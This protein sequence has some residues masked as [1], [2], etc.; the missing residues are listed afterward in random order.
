MMLDFLAV[1]SE[2]RVASLANMSV[3]FALTWRALALVILGISVLRAH[4]VMVTV[5]YR[6][7]RVPVALIVIVV[8]AVSLEVGSS[9]A[10][11][12]VGRVMRHGGGR[13]CGAGRARVH[14]LALV[15][16]AVAHSL[17]A[18]TVA[19]AVAVVAY[20]AVVGAS[21]TVVAASVPLLKTARLALDTST[22]STSVPVVAS[23]PAVAHL[24]LSSLLS[25]TAL[26]GPPLSGG[27]ALRGCWAG[28][29][30]ALPD[31]AG[32]RRAVAS[33]LL[34]G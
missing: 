2:E 28:T 4:G 1:C 5:V 29:H 15:Q 27:A 33:S 25:C 3:L 24:L 34:S 20:A 32:V 12:E 30:D 8:I 16:V 13:R 6:G 23:V 18:A 31:E 14:D 21:A 19:V 22:S 10:L 9:R 26:G 11:A 17:A 7:S